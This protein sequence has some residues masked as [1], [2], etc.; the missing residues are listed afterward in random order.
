MLNSEILEAYY[1]ITQ[2]PE[3]IPSAAIMIMMSDTIDRETSN[4]IKVTFDNYIKS[5]AYNKYTRALL[6]PVCKVI[7]E[8][9][10][11]LN[12]EILMLLRYLLSECLL[13]LR[14]FLL[15]SFEFKLC[16]I[17]I[18]ADKRAQGFESVLIG[19]VSLSRNLHEKLQLIHRTLIRVGLIL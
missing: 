3:N 11:S 12:S 7:I 10:D 4:T 15:Y 18:Q 17:P 5:L 1:Q 16:L 2:D 19:L 8:I 13:I 9:L 14:D 6:V